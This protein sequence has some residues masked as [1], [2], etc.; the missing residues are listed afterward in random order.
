MKGG[1]IFFQ[2]QKKPNR[3]LLAR[4]SCNP[5]TGNIDWSD[6]ALVLTAGPVPPAFLAPS[7]ILLLRSPTGSCCGTTQGFELLAAAKEAEY[8]PATQAESPEI[9]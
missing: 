9:H 3:H 5:L 6:N 7:G 8:G 1:L 2:P 4:F